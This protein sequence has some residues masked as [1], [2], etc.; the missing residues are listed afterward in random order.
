MLKDLPPIAIRFVTL[1][2]NSSLRIHHVLD[3]F[4]IAQII[5]I[6]KSRKDPELVTLDRLV[7]LLP[8]LLKVF[9]KRVASRLN[10]II[11]KKRFDPRTLLIWAGTCHRET[12]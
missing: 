7:S 12:G 1:L 4:K 9:E 11:M 2:Y 10:K 3:S 8:V 5:I 6:P